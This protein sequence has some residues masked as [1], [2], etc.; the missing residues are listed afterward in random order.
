MYTGFTKCVS[1]LP[2]SKKKIK[3]RD[4]NVQRKLYHLYQAHFFPHCHG[5]GLSRR[6][7]GPHE[8]HVTASRHTLPSIIYHHVIARDYKR[9]TQGAEK[10]FSWGHQSYKIKRIDSPGKVLMVYKVNSFYTQDSNGHWW[11]LI[12]VP[13]FPGLGKLQIFVNNFM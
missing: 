12:G 3:S 2:L 1:A 8:Q 4:K 10:L 7:H 11:S 13:L 9:R 5:A 6:Q